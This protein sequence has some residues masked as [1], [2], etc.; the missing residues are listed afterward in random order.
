MKEKLTARE[1]DVLNY[2]VE[3]KKTNGCSPTI[4]EIAEGINTK[5]LSHIRS[6]LVSLEEKGYLKFKENKHRTIKVLKF[7]S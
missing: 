4:I 3:Y 2:I 5:S 7:I 1:I 6:M